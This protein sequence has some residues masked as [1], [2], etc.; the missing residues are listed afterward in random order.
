MRLP[1][2]ALPTL[3]ALTFAAIVFA[4]TG[5]R[6]CGVG[7]ASAKSGFDSQYT[8]DQTWT[9][10]LRLVRVDLGLKVTEKDEHDGFILFE[11]VEKDRTSGA[12]IELVRTDH[13]VRVNCQ[14]AQF[15]SYHEAALLARLARKLKDEFG[16]PPERQPPDAGSI[17]A[18]ETGET[19]P[20]SP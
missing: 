12:S 15:A 16:A 18:D 20:T 10:S 14:I 17:D 1:I 11:Y 4:P 19:G 8:Y 5:M 2:L 3:T 9:A 13:G 6:E 7:V